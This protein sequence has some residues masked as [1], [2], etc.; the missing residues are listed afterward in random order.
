MPLLNTLHVQREW[1]RHPYAKQYIIYMFHVEHPHPP[2]V[3]FCVYIKK[4]LSSF[5]YNILDKKHTYLKG[6]F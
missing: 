3:H 1:H 2:Y 4:T 6:D 5:Y